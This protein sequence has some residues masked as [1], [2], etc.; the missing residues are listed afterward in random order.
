MFSMSSY[1]ASSSSTLVDEKKLVGGICFGSP[2]TISD[3]PR[4]MA[5][6]ASHVGI[7]EASSNTTRSNLS[8]ARLRYCATLIGLISIHGQRRG[9]NVGIFTK[10]SRM[11]SPRPP[12]LTLRL[13]RPISLLLSR[14]SVT[15]G[16]LAASREY[17][18]FCVSSWNSSV[19]RL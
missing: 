9:N 6:T 14:L 10:R 5:P 4:A 19:I 12:L 1:A 8:L 17:S 13:S 2:T 7:C 11:D 3:L 16:T 18:S 15:R